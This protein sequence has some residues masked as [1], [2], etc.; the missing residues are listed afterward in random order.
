MILSRRFEVISNGIEFSYSLI[1]GS[2]I[3]VVLKLL[4]YCYWFC[5]QEL[6]AEKE[7]RARNKRSEPGITAP[8]CVRGSQELSYYANKLS[9]L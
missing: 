8:R 3:K 5:W 6:D 2:G 7:L 1:K 4:R 9:K